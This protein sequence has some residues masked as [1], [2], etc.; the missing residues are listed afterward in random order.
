MADDLDRTD[1]STQIK[2]AINRAIK[3][4]E[5]E[6]FWFKDSSD[7]FPTVVGQKIYDSG[8]GLATDIGRITYAE[9]L[10]G[11]AKYELVAKDISWIQS[12]NPDDAQGL[13]NYYAR[14]GSD[15]WLCLVPNQVMTVTI[16]YKKKYTELSA[17]ADTNDWTTEAED[18][19]EARAR[20]WIYK[21]IIMDKV[22]ADEAKMEEIEALEALR[23]KN[24]DH[25]AGTYVEPTVF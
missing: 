9:I 8:D 7:T 24:E 19:I 11:T 6:P 17:D 23:S 10:Q 21:R 2:K 14:Y 20:W 1:L 3:H 18:L 25:A 4:Y 22:Q 12:Q 16:Y 5:K 15:I 13:P